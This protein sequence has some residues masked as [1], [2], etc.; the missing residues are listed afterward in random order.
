MPKVKV[1]LSA[2]HEWPDQEQAHEADNVQAYVQ[3]E[4]LIE[5]EKLNFSK[6][7]SQNESCQ[8]ENKRFSN[9]A[10]VGPNRVN[11]LLGVRANLCLPNI[12]HVKAHRDQRENA[13]HV[14]LFVLAYVKAYVG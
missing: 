13:A 3:T 1:I 6:R 4:Q 2:L 7:A 14:D 10:N 12:R 5:P 8:N 9:E 11:L